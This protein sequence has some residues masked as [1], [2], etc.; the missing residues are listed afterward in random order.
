MEELEHVVA[1]EYKFEKGAKK[2]AL[3]GNFGLSRH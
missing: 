2:V 1:E 3:F